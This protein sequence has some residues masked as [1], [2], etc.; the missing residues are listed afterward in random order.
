MLFLRMATQALRTATRPSGL[1]ETS[2]RAYYKRVFI[3]CLVLFI[4]KQIKHVLCKGPPVFFANPDGRGTLQ[5]IPQEDAPNVL[6]V[7]GSDVTPTQEVHPQPSFEFTLLNP[8]LTK[9]FCDG[10]SMALIYG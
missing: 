7:H 6:P 4:K 10:N 3:I 9:L 2:T 5:A 8:T 1:A